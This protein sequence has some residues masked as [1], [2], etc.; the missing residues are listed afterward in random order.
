MKGMFLRRAS[1]FLI[2]VFAVSCLLLFAVSRV[3]SAAQVKAEGVAALV[4]GEDLAKVHDEALRD[5]W[6]RAVEVGVGLV[7]RADVYVA[8]KQVISQEIKTSAEGYVKSYDIV[9]EGR[10]ASFYRLSILAEV[11]ML[12]IGQTL[13]D[14]GIEIGTI[15]NPRAV[16][17]VDEWNLGDK[18]PFSIAEAAVR[19][20]LLSKGFTIVQPQ[21]VSEN[22][23]SLQATQGDTRAAMEIARAF[24]AD[25]ALVGNVRT[26]PVGSMQRGSFTW[27]S[28]VAYADFSVVLRDTGETLSSVSAEETV[29][30][31]SMQAAGTEAIKSVTQKCLPQLVIETIAGLNYA[32]NNGIRALKLFVSGV[33]RFSQAQAIKQAVASLRETTRVDLRSFGEAVTSYDIVFLGPSEALAEELESQGFGSKLHELL[34]KS[35]KLVVHSLDFGVVNVE[36]CRK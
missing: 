27:H 21:E 28:A 17:V 11:D 36:L 4:K 35:Y 24:D 16:V 23:R 8:N 10:D 9:S 1:Y 26:D 7:L 20:E 18:Q 12:R 30:K 2:V 25:I 34:G 31:L 5:A 6:R 14:L 3:V 22:Q 19:A 15:G 32:R 29:A 33:A 13:D